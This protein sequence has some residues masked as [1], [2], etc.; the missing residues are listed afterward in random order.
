MG[1]LGEGVGMKK[2]YLYAKRR[3]ILKMYEDINVEKR[4][5]TNLSRSSKISNNAIKKTLVKSK[6]KNI[7]KK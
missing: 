4:E 5:K 3:E 7:Y 6:Y 2:E 1:V